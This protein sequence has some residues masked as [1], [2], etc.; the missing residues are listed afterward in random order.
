[1]RSVSIPVIVTSLSQSHQV[2]LLSSSLLPQD[3]IPLSV[4]HLLLEVSSDLDVETVIQ[5]DVTIP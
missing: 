3:R 1:M 5:I 2:D 4:L